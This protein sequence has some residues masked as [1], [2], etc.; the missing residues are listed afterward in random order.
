MNTF[1][2]FYILLPPLQLLVPQLTLILPMPQ[3]LLASF[4]F[5]SRMDLVLNRLSA[6]TN[7]SPFLLTLDFLFRSLV[8][9]P[10]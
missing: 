7:S 1:S 9:F 5:L 3:S 2:L 4:V 6:L 8:N 10:P